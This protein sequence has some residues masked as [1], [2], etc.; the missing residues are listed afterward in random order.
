MQWTNDLLT[1]WTVIIH[2]NAIVKKDVAYIVYDHTLRNV[3][4]YK[5]NSSKQN[6]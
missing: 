5:T 3:Y 6:V 1:S 4:I 2:S